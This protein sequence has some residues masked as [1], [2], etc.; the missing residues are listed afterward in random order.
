MFNTSIE[1][2]RPTSNMARP[3]IS[4]LPQKQLDQANVAAQPEAKQVAVLDRATL[5]KAVEKLNELVAPALQSLQFVIDDEA[6][7]VVVKVVDTETQKVLRQI[8]NEEVLAFSKTLGKFQG[9]L[10]REQV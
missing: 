4:P 9:L 6:D 10:L 2:Y 5:G 8:P 1:G 7:R 3:A